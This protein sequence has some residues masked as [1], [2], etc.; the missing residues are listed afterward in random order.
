MRTVE[1]LELRAI[2]SVIEIAEWVAAIRPLD[3]DD[4]GAEVGKHIAA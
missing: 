4:L 2:E 1:R 3:L